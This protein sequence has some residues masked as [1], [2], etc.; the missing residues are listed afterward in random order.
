MAVV[1]LSILR[2]RGLHAR[3]LVQRLGFELEC[4]VIERFALQYGIRVGAVNR[5]KSLVLLHSHFAA[6]V[7][8]LHPKHPTTTTTTTTEL[9]CWDGRMAPNLTSSLGLFCQQPLKPGGR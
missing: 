5:S 1:D 2:D 8:E 6:L 7:V 4:I 9:V 3:V